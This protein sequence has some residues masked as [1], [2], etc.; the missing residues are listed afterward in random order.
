MLE[1]GTK[2]LFVVALYINVLV[3]ATPSIPRIEVGLRETR[4]LLQQVPC[5]QNTGSHV[6]YAHVNIQHHPGRAN[7][8]T[9]TSRRLC[10]TRPLFTAF[11]NAGP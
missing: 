9:L 7:V 11:S 6:L 8:K 4:V 10:E 3:D 1:G 2:L 5:R